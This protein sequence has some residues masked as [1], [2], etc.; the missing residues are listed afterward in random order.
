MAALFKEGNNQK[1]SRHNNSNFKSEKIETNWIRDQFFYWNE[2]TLEYLRN[3]TAVHNIFQ[4]FTS[5]LAKVR[6]TSAEK[7]QPR[8]G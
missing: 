6:I 7:K 1:C 2:F 8:N 4:I 3:P 5:T